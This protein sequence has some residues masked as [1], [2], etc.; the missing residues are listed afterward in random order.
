M[1]RYLAEHP[2]VFDQDTI[3]L[4]SD[5]LDEAW[6]RIDP[7]WVA[8]DGKKAREMLAKHIVNQA[9]EGERDRARLVDKALLKFKH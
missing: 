6:Q 4:L 3:Q 5:A 2:H 9:K 8:V 1:K 7:R